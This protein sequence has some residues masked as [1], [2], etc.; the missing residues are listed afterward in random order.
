M[1][2]FTAK[3]IFSTSNL[4]FYFG[5]IDKKMGTLYNYNSVPIVLNP[6]YRG[7]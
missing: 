1:T 7:I 3:D 5:Q 6:T 2:K 4:E